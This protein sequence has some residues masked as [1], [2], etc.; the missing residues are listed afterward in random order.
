[1][2]RSILT[3]TA[4]ASAALCVFDPAI[5]QDDDSPFEEITVTAAKVRFLPLRSRSR[6]LL[7]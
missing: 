3:L 2:N 5:A 1:M 6:E 4:L 7:I